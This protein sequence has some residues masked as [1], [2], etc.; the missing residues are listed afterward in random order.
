ML[1]PGVVHAGM[2]SLTLTDLARMRIETISFFLLVLLLSALCIRLIWNR[3]AHDFT[4]LPRLSYGRALGLIVLWGLLFVL[5]LT[6]ISGARELLTPGAWEKHG[7]TYRLARPE[8][9]APAE[10]VPERERQEQLA[11]LQAA[12]W[13]YAQKHDGRLPDDR[14]ALPDDLWRVS[15]DPARHY[16]YAGGRELSASK[17]PVAWEPE[18]FGARRYVLFGDGTIRALTSNDLDAWLVRER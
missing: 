18:V 9:P 14:S 12:L 1:A 10:P 2:P 3:L 17:A 5:V 7:P 4:V 13:A 6:M 11:R 15:G 8:P 16:G